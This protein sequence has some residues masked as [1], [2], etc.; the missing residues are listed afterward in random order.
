[1]V[2]SSRD[3]G[4]L[5]GA[6]PAGVLWASDASERHADAPDG[7]VSVAG[8]GDHGATLR[9]LDFF[10][11]RHRGDRARTEDAARPAVLAG[12]DQVEEGPRTVQSLSAKMHS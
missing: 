6:S 10:L 5:G 4:F 3:R 1:M 2:P 8:H 7:R 11:V 12:L 9:V